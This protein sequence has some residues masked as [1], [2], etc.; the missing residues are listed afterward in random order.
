MPI[1]SADHQLVTHTQQTVRGGGEGKDEEGEE[2]E[3]GEGGGGEGREKEERGGS[4]RRKTRK[5]EGGKDL[6]LPTAQIF[7]MLWLYMNNQTLKTPQ[8]R[9][10]LLVCLAE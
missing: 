5:E 7:I 6:S 3:E 8:S 4:R 10:M 1:L 9:K 2:E